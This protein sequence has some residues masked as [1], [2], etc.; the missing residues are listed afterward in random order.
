MRLLPVSSQGGKP[1]IFKRF[2]VKKPDH[3]SAL[4]AAIVAAARQ[5]KFFADWAVP[6][7]VDGR[8][9]ILVLHMFLVLRRM[10]NDTPELCQQITDLFFKD[11]DRSLREMGVG[12]LSVGK[13]VRK[14]AEAFHGRLNAYAKSI[15]QDEASLIEALQRNVYGGAINPHAKELAHWVKSATGKLATQTTSSIQDAKLVFP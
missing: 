1:V 8:F 9:D 2:F 15:D 12:D 14:M 5:P 4:Y 11:M 3:A 7:T 6:D 10:K 13:K